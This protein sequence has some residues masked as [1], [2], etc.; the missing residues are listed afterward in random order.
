VYISVH[1][2]SDT[3]GKRSSVS[4]KD[5]EV[6]VA[7]VSSDK[8]KLLDISATEYECTGSKEYKRDAT[9]YLT[10]KD[11]VKIIDAAINH[12]IIEINNL[13]VVKY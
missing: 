4:S 7:V 12:K 8:Q 1:S 3:P 11:L 13:I 6:N 9:V 2:A 5:F 10:G